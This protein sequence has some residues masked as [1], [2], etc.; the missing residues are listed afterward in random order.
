MNNLI[1]NRMPAR[2]V[3]KRI[4]EAGTFIHRDV[5]LFDSCSYREG[6][7]FY[8]VR[9]ADGSISDPFLRL[10]EARECAMVM[11]TEDLKDG[12]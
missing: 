8:T 1:I 5:G 10:W 6:E 9:Y 3:T 11:R 4:A 12:L 7:T 2:E